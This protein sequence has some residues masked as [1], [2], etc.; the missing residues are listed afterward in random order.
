MS[1]YG[2][3]IVPKSALSIDMCLRALAGFEVKLGQTWSKHGP[4]IV[5]KSK[6]M[7]RYTPL[8]FNVC[9]DAFRHFLN[10]SRHDTDSLI[11]IK[12]CRIMMHTYY[13]T[14]QTCFDMLSKRSD[15][16]KPFPHMS[17]HIS[18]MIRHNHTFTLFQTCEHM[19]MTC[20]NHVQTYRGMLWACPH[21]FLTCS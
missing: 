5:P 19:F 13:R 15:T 4:Y 20:S 7:F 8:M 1:R 6:H 16:S 14:N 21:R 10:M 12:T 18:E 9:Q 2:P 11:H 3:V 17:R